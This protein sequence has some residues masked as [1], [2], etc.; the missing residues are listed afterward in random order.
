M[1]HYVDSQTV[2]RC[3]T[4]AHQ[5]EL[6]RNGYTHFLDTGDVY[7]RDSIDSTH[8]PVFHQYPP[9]YKDMSFWISDS[10]TENSVKLLE[11]LLETLPRS[12]AKS[13]NLILSIELSDFH[14]IPWGGSRVIGLSSE[15]K[16]YRVERGPII[17]SL[18]DGSRQISWSS[19]TSCLLHE[20][21]VVTV[22]SIPTTVRIAYRSMDRSLT[23]EEINDLQWKVREQVEN[24]LKVVLR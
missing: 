11:E 24:K 21:V 3:H 6:L 8:Y 23:D 19:C 9:C 12:Y 22:A 4:S 20:F 7:R 1:T 5:A 13:S 18:K 2:L 14:I 15:A 16:R 17:P 10:F